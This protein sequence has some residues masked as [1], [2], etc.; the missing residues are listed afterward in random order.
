MLFQFYIPEPFKDVFLIL[1]RFELIRDKNSLDLGDSDN[2]LFND[3]C[4]NEVSSSTEAE[5]R[6]YAA[7]GCK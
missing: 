7:N 1:G 4:F 2:P 5:F 6:L 3:C